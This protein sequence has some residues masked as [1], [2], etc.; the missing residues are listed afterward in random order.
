MSTV[1][2]F[3]LKAETSCVKKVIKPIWETRNANNIIAY[4]MFDLFIIK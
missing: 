3:A 1:Y 2:N 4:H